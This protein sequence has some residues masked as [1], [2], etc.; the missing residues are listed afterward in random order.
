MEGQAV[1]RERQ[2]AESAALHLASE[3]RP[4]A[5]G[6]VVASPKPLVFVP[7]LA[8]GVL[9]WA[10][11]F[12]LACGWLAWVALV[13]LLCLVRSEARPRRIY[14]AAWLCGLAFFWPAIA[15]MRVADWR[16]WFTWAMLAT[17][18]SLYVPVAVWLVRRLDSATP[19]PLVLSFPAVWCGL[20]FLRSFLGSGFA[21][22]FLGHSQH[23]F[24]PLI[25]IADLG[26][27]YAVSFLVAA[28]NVWLFECLFLQ[29]WFRNFVG[30]S[31]A[32]AAGARALAA[33]GVLL[34]ALLGGSLAYGAWRLGQEDFEPGPRVA[35]LQGNLDQRLRNQVHSSTVAATK[36]LY[37]YATLSGM[38]ARAPQR[39]D[40]IVW[41]ETSF[42]DDWLVVVSDEGLPQWL[43]CLAALAPTGLPAD[44]PRLGLTWDRSY[45]AAVGRLRQSIRSVGPDFHTSVLLGLNAEDVTRTGRVQRRYCSALLVNS[46]G[47]IGDRYDK[48]HRVPFGEYVPLRD[49]L[50]FMDRFAPYD[51]AYSITPG[52]RFTRFSVGAHRFGVLICFEVSDPALARR[53]AVADEDGP[54]VDFL[55]EISNDGWF[56][57]NSEHDEHLAICRFRAIEAR[58]AVGRAVNMGISAVIDGNGRVLA[59]QTCRSDRGINLWELHAAKGS[60]STLP[61]SDWAGFKKVQGVLTATIPIDQRASLYAQWGDWFGWGCLLVAGAALAWAKIRRHAIH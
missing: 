8:S 21:W 57:G 61:V 33:Q 29:L 49:V 24:L 17:Y 27:V 6:R 11:F 30:L 19:L 32:S 15:W 41:P 50:P 1:I 53:Y 42:P 37:H 51:F 46:D 14:F 10:C 9:L 47:S 48:M 56:D 18:C 2:A 34:A 7:A 12:P 38:A 20:E 59:P 31:G 60:M 52:T 28:V 45:N 26:G 22:Y 23:T 35:L 4:G 55:L 40:L 25:Q 54:P 36:M 3:Q 58:R 13:P 44:L 39:P 43:V 5:Q 16:M